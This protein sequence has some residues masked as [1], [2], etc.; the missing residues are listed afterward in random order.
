MCQ[1]VIND[2]GFQKVS[3]YDQVG[4]LVLQAQFWWIGF[5]TISLGKKERVALLLLCSECDVHAQ[6]QKILTEG[7]QL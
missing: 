7:I 5:A 4:T 1:Y 3:E 6:I 2:C